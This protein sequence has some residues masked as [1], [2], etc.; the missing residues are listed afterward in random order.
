MNRS[1]SL[2]LD[3]VRFGAAVA[4]LLS[5][6][7]MREIIATNLFP[8]SLGHNAVVVFFV[9]SGY[10]IAY[11]T[12]TREN[13]WH[14]YSISRLARVYS[15]ALPAIVLVPLLDAAGQAIGTALYDAGNTTHD[16]GLVRVVTSALFVN[17]LWFVSIMPFSNSPYWSL[18]YEVCYYVLFAVSQ[19]ESG[20]RRVVL[21]VVACLIMGPK[22]LL[23]LPIWMVGVML[24]R[25]RDRFVISEFNGWLLISASLIGAVIYYELG[26]YDLLSNATV[27]MVGTHW[28]KL[29][30]FSQHF[31]ADYV[32][33]AVVAANFLGVRA[34]ARGRGGVPDPVARWIK[35][36]SAYTFALY[37]FHLPLILFFATVVNGNPSSSYFYIGVVLLSFTTA[38]LIGTGTEAFKDRLR[39]WLENEVAPSFANFKGWW[40]RS[41]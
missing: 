14:T 16:Y 3:V 13:T 6:A 39:H 30:H 8:L 36:L 1:F 24:Y 31:L 21:L 28:A 35:R 33:T 27:R 32:F 22:I 12:D 34:I 41:G 29:L 23:L 17:E 18:S 15:V 19:F 2:Y 7:N 37:L 26:L 40:A 5:H 11:V 9:L 25:M 38:M 4:V 10:V 20:W